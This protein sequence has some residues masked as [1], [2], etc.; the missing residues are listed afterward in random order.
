MYHCDRRWYLLCCHFL[1]VHFNFHNLANRKPNPIVMKV[2]IV[3]PTRLLC[4]LPDQ[5]KSLAPIHWHWVHFIRILMHAVCLPSLMPDFHMFL[6]T[7]TWHCT[8]TTDARCDV[9]SFPMFKAC[10]HVSFCVGRSLYIIQDFCSKLEGRW[11]ETNEESFR[12]FKFWF[13]NIKTLTAITIWMRMTA[14]RLPHLVT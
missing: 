8:F 1:T 7:F 4:C 10:S 3:L 6:A 13:H 12:Y 11:N 2:V 14:A 5:L 9:T